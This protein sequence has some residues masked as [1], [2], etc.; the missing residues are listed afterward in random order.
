MSST[1]RLA[2]TGIVFLLFGVHTLACTVPRIDSPKQL[3]SNAQGIYRAR[4]EE[5]VVETLADR[6]PA[7]QIRFAIIETVKGPRL[8]S[9]TLEGVLTESD[10]RYDRPVPYDF[11][12]LAGRMGNCYAQEYARG[13]E[14][15]FLIKD[16]TP[17][18]SPLAPTNEQVSGDSDPWVAWVRGRVRLLRAL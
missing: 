11:V 2:V 9:L 3:V 7:T 4:A 17:Y 13:K 18:W 10:D 5:Y 8:E 14:F 16:G 1:L 12:R 6:R 15:L